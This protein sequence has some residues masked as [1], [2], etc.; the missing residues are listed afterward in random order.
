MIVL[1]VHRWKGRNQRIYTNTFIKRKEILEMLTDFATDSYIYKYF[2][3]VSSIAAMMHKSSFFG[4]LLQLWLHNIGNT[5][6]KS[7]QKKGEDLCC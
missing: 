2:F 4:Y 5:T 7:M 3:H 6:A 1:F